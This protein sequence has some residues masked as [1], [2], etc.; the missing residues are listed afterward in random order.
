MVELCAYIGTRGIV[1]SAIAAVDIALWDLKA[2]ILESS[3]V[4]SL[5]A[6]I[7]M[8]DNGEPKVSLLYREEFTY[9]S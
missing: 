7:K 2:K 5:G 4:R 1:A 6:E 3:F 8:F 9:A